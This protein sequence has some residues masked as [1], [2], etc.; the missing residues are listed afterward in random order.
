MHPLQKNMLIVIE[1]IDG[2]GKSTLAT[3]LN[4]ALQGNGLATTL[5]K[6]PGGSQLGKWF[7]Q[8]MVEYQFPL[9]TK[10]EFLLFAAD[11]A[12]HMA[13]TVNPALAE[14]KIVIS[15]RMSDSSV[16][17][18]GYGRGISIDLINQ[19]NTWIMDG[20]TADITFYLKISLEKAQERL[21]LRGQ[22]LSVFEKEEEFVKKIMHGFD[23]IFAN[24]ANVITLDGSL[25]VEE[26]VNQATEKTM[27]WLTQ[28][29]NL[30]P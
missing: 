29:K 30:L 7:R 3:N 22:K 21:K 10:A 16:V 14:E 12:Q 24:R 23:E 18:Q 4:R 5:T 20:K 1:G 8:L 17:Y 27:L 19:I 11:R 15:D 28:K 26:L 13:E 25:S 2:A 9:A 6:E